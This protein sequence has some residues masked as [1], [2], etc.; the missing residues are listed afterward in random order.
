MSRLLVKSILQEVVKMIEKPP[1]AKIIDAL[2][3]EAEEVK[4]DGS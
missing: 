4:E 1:Y 3:E 2:K